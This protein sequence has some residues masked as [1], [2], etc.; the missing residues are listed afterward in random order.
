[1][2]KEMDVTDGTSNTYLIGEKYM[3]PDHYETGEDA[4]D[5]EAA[6][7][8]DNQD[9]SRWT[10]SPPQVDTPGVA[11]GVIFG[12]AHDNVFNMAFCDGSVQAMSYSIDPIVHNY[13]GNRMDGEPIDARKL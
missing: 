8:G 2:I 12:S 3:D 10:F 1:M 7:I 11:N 5:N 6:L 4:A 9:I 13:L